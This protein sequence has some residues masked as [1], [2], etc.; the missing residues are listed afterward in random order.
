MNCQAKALLISLA[1]H[2]GIVYLMFMICCSFDHAGK[3]VLIDFTL[4]DSKGSESSGAEK[5]ANAKQSPRTLAGPKVTEKK[6]KA[7]L[8]KPRV[9]EILPSHPKPIQASATETTGTVAV[10]A[11]PSPSAMPVPAAIAQNRP[12]GDSAA[13]SG[14]EG[15]SGSTGSGTGSGQGRGEGTSGNGTGNS[16]E[17]MR[18]RYLKEH[19]EYIRG[20]IQK[21]LAYPVRAR[22]MGWEGRTV[23]SFTI[24]ENGRVQNIKILNSSGYDLLDDNVLDTIT[25]VEPFPKPPVRAELRIP[26]MYR[27]N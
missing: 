3:P 14:R 2:S 18:N 6:R 10:P 17:Q 5:T 12:S 19:F 13:K 27:L 26:I 25:K 21:N 22:R 16:T 7:I 20:L 8:E 15:G 9:A 1:V 11:A 23:V 24:L 4:L